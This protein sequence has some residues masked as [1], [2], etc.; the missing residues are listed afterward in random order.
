MLLLTIGDFL[1]K[2]RRKCIGKYLVCDGRSDCIDGSDEV[3]CP[4]VAAKTTKPPP[5]RC[6]FGTKPCKDS[7]DCVLLSHVCDGEVDCKDG[8]D[9]EG[10]RT[11]CSPGEFYFSLTKFYLF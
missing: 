4:T 1:C 2:D 3:A 11:Q 9:E 5:L 6:R 10:C 7:S 8:S